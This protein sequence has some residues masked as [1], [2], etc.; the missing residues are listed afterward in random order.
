MRTIVIAGAALLLSGALPTTMGGWA[1]ITVKELPDHIEAGRATSIEFTVRQHGQTLLNGL[2]PRVVARRKGAGWFSS[3]ARVRGRSNG[4]EGGYVAQLT[5][6]DTGEVSVTIDADWHS[7]ET[8]L[9]P[10]RVVAPGHTPGP[11]APAAL[12]QQLFVAKGC[13]TCHLKADDPGLRD[14]LTVRVGPDLSGTRLT[15]AYVAGKLANPAL[16]RVRSNA[17]V[18]MPDLGLTSAEI[19]ALVTYLTKGTVQAA[20]R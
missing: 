2:S 16:N 4:Q 6:A 10:I 17:Y 19:A 1:V 15:A 9:L 20:G 11:Q 5:L 7:A 3:P 12:G 14:R 8:T 18:E 13:V